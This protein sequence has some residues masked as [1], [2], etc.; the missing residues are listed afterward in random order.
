MECNNVKYDTI[1][2]ALSMG[3]EWFYHNLL[4]HMKKY[5][6]M[7]DIPTMF[8]KT[9]QFDN[10]KAQKGSLSVYAK[11]FIKLQQKINDRKIGIKERVGG[12]HNDLINA[13]EEF[14]GGKSH[15]VKKNTASL[16]SILSHTDKYYRSMSFLFFLFN[17]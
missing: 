15:I 1:W 13:H 10:I 6:Y 8:Q 7:V 2:M 14:L 17:H 11:P 12:F 5:L 9:K 3:D 16:H 4:C